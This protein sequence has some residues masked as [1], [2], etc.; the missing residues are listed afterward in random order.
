MTS[1]QQSANNSKSAKF[2]QVNPLEPMIKPFSN[3]QIVSISKA[4]V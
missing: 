1:Y 3:G 2:V 4:N